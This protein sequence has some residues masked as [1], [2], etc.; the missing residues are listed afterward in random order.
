M[1]GAQDQ[2]LFHFE[3]CYRGGS[4]NGELKDFVAQGTSTSGQGSQGTDKGKQKVL[5]WDAYQKVGLNEQALKKASPLYG[6]AN[7]PVEVKG[8]ITLHI[9]LRDDKNSTKKK[10][11]S[12]LW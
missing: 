1:T 5:T 3:R 12:S 8:C 7:Y 6:F 10:M 11:F 9:T 4:Y 2:G